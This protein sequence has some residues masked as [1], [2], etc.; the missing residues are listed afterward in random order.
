LGKPED[1]VALL[2]YLVSEQA[3]HV[4]GQVFTLKFP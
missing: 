2:L 3:A 1:I 4:T